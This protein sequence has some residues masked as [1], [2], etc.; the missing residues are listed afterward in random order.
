MANLVQ[1]WMIPELNYLMFL[2]EVMQNEKKLYTIFSW[3]TMAD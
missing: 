2:N 1:I 3:L